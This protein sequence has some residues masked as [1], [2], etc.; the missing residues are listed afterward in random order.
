[1][2]EQTISPFGQHGLYSMQQPTVPEV[3]GEIFQAAADLEEVSVVAV[4]LEAS[5][6][7]VRGVA[8]LG[9]VGDESI[10]V[11][12]IMIRLNLIGFRRNDN[13]FNPLS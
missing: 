12:P 5:A 10:S 6:E 2:H 7:E 11:L 8:V 4:V 13:I 3:P 9:G 1:M